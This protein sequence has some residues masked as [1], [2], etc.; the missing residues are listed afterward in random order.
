LLLLG[1]VADR[2]VGALA[3]ERDGH[4]PADARVPARD[5][6]PAA[7]EAAA[8]AVRRLAVVGHGV[9]GPGEAGGLLL[10]RREA[11]TVRHGVPPRPVGSALTSGPARDDA[12]AAP[13]ARG[14]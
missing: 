1:Q 2:D 11:G 4:R 6:R 5:E 13:R 7:V 9:H 8:A 10:L 14:A 12:R 3:R